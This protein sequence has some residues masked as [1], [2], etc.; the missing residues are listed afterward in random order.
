MF[1]RKNNFGGKIDFSRIYMICIYSRIHVIMLFM[2]RK[3]NKNSEQT[4]TVVIYEVKL[5]MFARLS[6]LNIIIKLPQSYVHPQQYDV[7]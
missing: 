6:Q 1:H 3:Y 2:Q 5:Q 4:V 7:S